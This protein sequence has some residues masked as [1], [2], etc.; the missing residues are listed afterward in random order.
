M[1]GAVNGFEL[2]R[3]IRQVRP[4]VGIVLV[5]GRT[6]PADGVLFLSKPIRLLR[7]LRHQVAHRDERP[8][9]QQHFI[10]G[11]SR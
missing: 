8:P 4:R 5:S 3:R 1:P 7:L 6:A 10:G 9:S 2:A 11:Q